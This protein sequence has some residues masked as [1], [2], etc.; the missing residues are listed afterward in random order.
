M[1]KFFSLILGLVIAFPP[2]T[3]PETRATRGQATKMIVGWYL[4]TAPGVQIFSIPKK[5]K[6]YHVLTDKGETLYVG[7]ILEKLEDDL[8]LG[9]KKK[10]WYLLPDVGNVPSNQASSLVIVIESNARAGLKAIVVK[11]FDL[12]Q[13]L[14][15]NYVDN[16][17]KTEKLK[18]ISYGIRS[19]GYK[20]ETQRVLI[21]LRSNRNRT[22]SDQLDRIVISVADIDG[23]N[24]QERHR[25]RKS[26][27]DS[28]DLIANLAAMA[29]INQDN[30]ADVLLIDQGDFQG[31]LLLIEKE[32]QWHEQHD[33]WGEPC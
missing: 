25:Y 4:P 23:D 21:I 14:L 12:D 28:G 2:C 10:N 19:I 22:S 32:N 17:A 27:G 5:N 18:T 20:G 7:K 3:Y 15:S 1:S 30:L 6:Y 26:R 16:I 9:G 29:D 8:C 13:Q 24:I 33:D 11:P 31:K